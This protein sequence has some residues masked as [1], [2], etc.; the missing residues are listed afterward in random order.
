MIVA[1]RYLTTG[2]VTVT[3]SGKAFNQPVSYQY[4]F[5]RVDT[6]ATRYQF[7]IKIWAKQKI[8]NLLV[9]YYALTPGSPQALEM[10]IRDS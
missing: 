10:C 3:L 8:D 7:L 5:N 6:T 9:Q 2:P 4:T 1:G